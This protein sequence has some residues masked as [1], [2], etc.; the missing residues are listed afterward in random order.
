MSHKCI[1]ASYP[2]AYKYSLQKFY[3]FSSLFFKCWRN[4]RISISAT[5]YEHLFWTKSYTC[6]FYVLHLRVALFYKCE[7]VGKAALK[8]L[9]KL[10]AEFLSSFRKKIISVREQFTK[11]GK[12]S[13]WTFFLMLLKLHEVFYWLKMTHKYFFF[14][15][16]C[17]FHFDWKRRGYIASVCVSRER[18]KEGGSLFAFVMISRSRI[19]QKS[20]SANLNG[21]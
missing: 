3:L 10:I 4:I 9:V 2:E 20:F 15:Q 7:A 1:K 13:L 6:S 11:I 8:M 17:G 12:K 21:L 19:P 14:F 18:E 16:F 5:Y